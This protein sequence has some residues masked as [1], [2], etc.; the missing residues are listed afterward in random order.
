MIR[1][2]VSHV[3]TV[4]VFKHIFRRT[5]ILALNVGFVSKDRTSSAGPAL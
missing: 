1:I 4:F 3:C 2:T 5:E